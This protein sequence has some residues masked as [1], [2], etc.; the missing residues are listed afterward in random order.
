MT[1]L[2]IKEMDKRTDIANPTE[3]HEAIVG[4]GMSNTAA[5]MEYAKELGVELFVLEVES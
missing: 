4:E 1:A 5:V 2:H 3:Y